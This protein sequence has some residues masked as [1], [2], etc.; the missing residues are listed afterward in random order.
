MAYFSNYYKLS[1]SHCHCSC[2]HGHWLLNDALHFAI[3]LSS[4]F[5]LNNEVQPSF[6]NLME[7]ESSFANE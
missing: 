5:F 3:S 4:I 7:D 2:F 1:F 6:E